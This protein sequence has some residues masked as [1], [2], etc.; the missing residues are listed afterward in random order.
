MKYL[1]TSTLLCLSVWLFAQNPSEM[2]VIPE[3]ILRMEQSGWQFT[4]LQP[5]QEVVGAERLDIPLEVALGA[6]GLRPDKSVLKNVATTKP[7]ALDVVI[8]V[9]DEAPITVR[10]HRVEITAAEMKVM[11]SS[12][13]SQT[14]IPGAFY[15]G[16]VKGDY[17]SL[18]ALSF[19]DDHVRGMLMLEDRTLVLGPLEGA[20]NQ[21]IHIV[22]DEELI[23]HRNPFTCL[24]DELDH[25]GVSNSDPL[26]IGQR[27][28]G[29]CVNVY[30]EVN[31][32]IWQD[33]GANTL[34]Y[35]TGA[36]NEVFTLYDND[37]IAAASSEIKIWNTVSPYPGPGSI[38]FLFQFRDHLSGVYN[39]DIAHLLGYGGG[40]GVAYLDVLCAKYWSV[41]YSGIAGSYQNVPTYSWTI[42][43]MAHEMGH[44]LGSPHTHGCAWNGNNTK[45]DDCGGNAGYSEGNCG[46]NP[47]DP[48]TGGTVMSYCHL[49]PVGINL[50]EGFGPQPAALM[51]SRIDGANCLGDCGGIEDCAFTIT[52][53]ANT[54]VQC[55]PNPLPGVTGN[56]TVTVTEGS[57]DP[58]LTWSDNNNGLT[59]CNG[60][61]FFIRTFS[62]TDGIS[63]ASCAQ[64]I[65]KIDNVPPTISGVPN[66]ITINCLAPVPN[67]ANPTATD[68]CGVATLTFS[69]MTGGGGN[70]CGYTIIR[71][72]TAT[73]ACNNQTMRTSDSH[74]S[75]YFTTR[76][77]LQ[78]CRSICQQQW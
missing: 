38:D 24:T 40:G 15:R 35:I 73:D 21:G 18:V 48:A 78:G 30:W 47:P 51:I 39:G 64:T 62:A 5:F 61:G 45:I 11:Y 19:Y 25:E 37:G 4:N 2:K 42:M 3:R 46:A 31:Y 65:T 49:R 23:A 68:N 34:N 72:W 32:N 66:D 36:T 12:G 8:P 14:G 53:P 13:L 7:T 55:G 44:N 22:Y 10:V 16:I 77:P 27:A 52:C 58:D 71:T 60:T 28:P 33:K 56:A 75:R 26:E 67:P 63:T 59:G 1:F 9:P 76:S 29:D 74:R 69:E 17:Q 70:V 50:G 20:S 57:C 6:W 54:T 41:A 43:V